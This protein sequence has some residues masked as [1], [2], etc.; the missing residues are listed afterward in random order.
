MPLEPFAECSNLQMENYI[1]IH[2]SKNLAELI[3][4]KIT[5]DQTSKLFIIKVFNV[6]KMICI[7]KHVSSNLLQENALMI[8]TLLLNVHLKTL[9]NQELQMKVP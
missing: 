7:S 9:I 6:V 1:T 4:D 5:A 3:M 8:R 2:N